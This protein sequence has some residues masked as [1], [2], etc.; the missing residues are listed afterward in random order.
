MNKLIKRVAFATLIL[1]N[2]LLVSGCS[3]KEQAPE[4]IFKKNVEIP[5]NS[6][7]ESYKLIKNI[8]GTTSVFTEVEENTYSYD[9]FK[10]Y[11]PPINTKKIGKQKIV[12]KIDDNKYPLTIKI[13]DKQK[14][15][16]ELANSDE[17]G[18]QEV[19][20]FN[21]NDNLKKLKFKIKDNVN[22]LKDLN[23]KVNTNFKQ[24]KVGE[25]SYVIMAKDKEGNLGVKKLRIRVIE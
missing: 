20:I 7:F 13:V 2:T 25:Y 17:L 11:C 4:I 10:V 14:P 23:V 24:G 3:F 12:Y 21:K 1:L 8:D 16:I 19:I 6:K 5:Q 15:K 18:D 22:E 9:N